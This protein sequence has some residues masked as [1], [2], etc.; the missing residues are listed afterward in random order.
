MVD[1]AKFSAGVN[2]SGT[3]TSVTAALG[4][5][6][7]STMASNGVNTGTSSGSHGR[8]HSAGKVRS[9]QETV[10]QGPAIAQTQGNQAS[11]YVGPN[12]QPIPGYA[13]PKSAGAIRRSQMGASASSPVVVA[14]ATTGPTPQQVLYQPAAQHQQYSGQQNSRSSSPSVGYNEQTKRLYY[15][16]G[17]QPN[18]RSSPQ[19]EAAASNGYAQSG[20]IPYSAP[21]SNLMSRPQN[22]VTTDLGKNS[23]SSSSS[24]VPS[25]QQF[26]YQNNADIANRQ[27]YQEHRQAGQSAQSAQ[28]KA[29]VSNGADQ[30][31][32]DAAVPAAPASKSSPTIS[33]TKKVINVTRP[34]SA[35]ARLR[36]EINSMKY[37]D[38]QGPPASAPQPQ[39][40]ASSQAPTADQHRPVQAARVTNTKEPMVGVQGLEDIGGPDPM[41]AQGTQGDRLREMLLLAREDDDEMDGYRPVV[42]SRSH[43]ETL[44]STLSGGLEQA[45]N[46]LGLVGSQDSLRTDD[47]LDVDLGMSTLPNQFCTVRDALEL[48]K[49]LLLS[50][51]TRGGMVPSSTAVMDMYMVGR[52]VGVGSYGKVRAAWHRLTGAKVAIKTYDKAKLKDPAHWKRVNS[53]IKIMEQVSHPRIARLYEAVETPKRM[54][55]IMECLEG[56]DLCSYVKQKRR[57][58]EDESR[59]IFFQVLQAIEHL[60]MLGVAHRDVK[61]EN[62]LFVDGK[63]VKLIDFGFS[64]VCQADKK[65]KVFC[66]TPSCKSMRS[67]RAQFE[68]STIKCILA[69]FQCRHGT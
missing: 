65:L 67:L 41:T 43:P 1:T 21:Q 29:A 50:N 57:L 28:P 6:Y 51:V 40:A 36:T 64:T 14:N 2:V 26:Q 35:A 15:S 44:S 3:P 17:V 69:L 54:H 7:A 68:V 62:V 39:T 60:H 42:E 34:Q 11:Q 53:E 52:V 31:G 25:T 24:G 19:L 27:L 46:G 49:L 61:L 20:N 9:G 30:I 32:G 37:P 58:S 12:G 22:I 13:R 55:L 10:V 38:S 4:P 16:G 8:P 33:D 47:L 56:G 23:S 66:G 59:S 18:A 5:T 45:S 48:K 63:D